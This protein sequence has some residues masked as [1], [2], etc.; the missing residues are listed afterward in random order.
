MVQF[1][2]SAH[3]V[4]F[5]SFYKNQA[6]PPFLMSASDFINARGRGAACKNSKCRHYFESDFISSV[7]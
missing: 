3:K 6:V 1:K 5:V 4:W 2:P 7:V